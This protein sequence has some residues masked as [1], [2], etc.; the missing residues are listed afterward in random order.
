MHTLN[1]ERN[2]PKAGTQPWRNPTERMLKIKIYG[3]KNQGPTT[4]TVAPGERINLPAYWSEA[5]CRKVCKFIVPEAEW[6]AMNEPTGD[7][8]ERPTR[9]VA[10]AP[11]PPEASAPLGDASK[12]PDEEARKEQEKPEDAKHSSGDA[13]EA[14][15]QALMKKPKAQLV[16]MAEGMGIDIADNATK[17]TVAR[18]IALKSV[19]DSKAD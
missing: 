16:S 19:E 10:N 1:K 3:G 6:D 18:A 14:Y 4:H 8:D 2:R 7:E 13:L 12:V 5:T 15:A 11:P 17:A 9:E